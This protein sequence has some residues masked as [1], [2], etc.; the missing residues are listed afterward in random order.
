LYEL[1]ANYRKFTKDNS[2]ILEQRPS[3]NE[4]IK[5]DIKKLKNKC[6]ETK[7]ENPGEEKIC[8]VCKEYINGCCRLKEEIEREIK[9]IWEG[10]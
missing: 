1:D 9:A 3:L 2:A 4:S 7:K 5:K 6:M 10:E 8:A